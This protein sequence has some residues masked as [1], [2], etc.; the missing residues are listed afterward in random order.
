[1][2]RAELTVLDPVWDTVRDFRAPVLCLHCRCPYGTTLGYFWTTPTT[3]QDDSS[4]PSTA[5][6]LCVPTSE[7]SLS[8]H[9][10]HDAE[11]PST[12]SSHSFKAQLTQRLSSSI[13]TFMS[14]LLLLFPY[15]RRFNVLAALLLLAFPSPSYGE[16]PYDPSPTSP[17]YDGRSSVCLAAVHAGIINAS[18]GGGVYVSRFYRHAWTNTSSQTI[19]PYPSNLSSLSNGVQSSDVDDSWYSLPSTQHE[20]SYTVR[21][22]GDYIVQRREAPFPPRA[23]HLHLTFARPALDPTTLFHIIIGGYNATHYLNDVWL[24][25][26]PRVLSADLSWRRLADAPFSPRSDVTMTVEMTEIMINP[27]VLPEMGMS[28]LLGGQTAHRCGLRELGVCSD[29]AWGLQ[30]S[31]GED[32]TGSVL[33]TAMPSLQLPFTSRCGAALLRRPSVLIGGTLPVYLEVAG[34]QLSYDDRSCSSAPVTVNDVWGV[35]YNQTTAQRVGEWMQR[36]PAPFSPRRVD[37][38]CVGLAGD[39]LCALGGGSRHLSISA[40][41]DDEARLTATVQYMDVWRC[42]MDLRLTSPPSACRFI[43]RPSHR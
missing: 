33:W 18:T 7:L 8:A 22:R 41:G 38:R 2:W 25:E 12:R 21:G 31:T 24:A 28:I 40:V 42:Q 27:S 19:F 6:T 17:P 30:L 34:G 14:P 39:L 32:G 1:M 43:C 3:E 5:A 15:L 36:S 37:A 16:G 10:P 35:E 20:W 26:Q 11:V 29:D 4:Q 9:R 23:G 13:N